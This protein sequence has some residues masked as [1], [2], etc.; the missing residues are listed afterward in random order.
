[1]SKPTI[2]D[3]RWAV[4][5]ASV[6]SANQSNPLSGLKDTGW[7]DHAKPTA[8]NLNWLLRK[9]HRWFK[10]LDTQLDDVTE[11]IQPIEFK[12]VSMGGSPPSPNDI[13]QIAGGS[14]ANWTIRITG[15]RVGDT[16]VGF[17]ARVKDDGASVPHSSASV[18]LFSSADGVASASLGS[19]T[20]T[21]TGAEQ[22]LSVTGLT[23]AVASLTSYLLQ[24]G[25]GL[26]GGGAGT[27][28]LHYWSVLVQ[29]P[30][31]P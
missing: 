20:S 4:D 2:D 29:R 12:G 25:F 11:L 1:M 19:V 22:T 13:I 15:L 26:T 16:I 28:T 18:S 24:L 30:T 21:A 7:P 27:L 31:T 14:P 8:K 17:K 9:G 3:T 10:W 23:V 6:E 5:G